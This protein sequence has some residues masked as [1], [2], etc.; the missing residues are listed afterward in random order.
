MPPLIARMR[1]PLTLAL[2][3]L[4]PPGC[5]T[6]GDLL[7][8]AE[9]RARWHAADLRDY[10]YTFTLQ[11]FCAPEFVQPVRILVR[12]RQPV[13]RNY[14]DGGP[15]PE[16]PFAQYD[17]IEEIFARLEQAY[18]AGAARI[19]AEFDPVLGFPRSFY[20]DRNEMIADEETGGQI[21]DFAQS[22][23]ASP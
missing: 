10:E 9:A 6:D 14:E 3:S 21:R 7:S 12:N 17:T 23:P 5:C 16:Q 2:I 13:S 1:I 8:L 4:L 19:D 18:L 15:A 22:P 11:C 20:I